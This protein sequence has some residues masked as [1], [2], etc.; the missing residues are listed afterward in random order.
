MNIDIAYNTIFVNGEALNCSYNMSLQ[1]LLLY[2][3]F[4][5]NIIVVEYNKE[6]VTNYKFPN[7]VLKDQ[8]KL[9]VITIVGGG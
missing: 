3:G 5:I 6:I 7:I 1:D 4:D 2:L 9:E 8:D